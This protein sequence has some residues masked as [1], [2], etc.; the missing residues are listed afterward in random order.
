MVEVRVLKSAEIG[1][2]LEDIAALRSTVFR[3]WP[4][5]YDGS[6]DYE[7][8]YIAGYRDHPGALIV[9]ALDGNRLVGV[10][11]STPMEDLGADFAEPFP[12]AGPSRDCILWGPESVLQPTFRDQ[13]IG[14][15]FYA[16]R[17]AHARALGRTH[18][19]FA[20]VLRPD[21]HPARPV[22]ARTTDAFWRRLGYAPS[23]GFVAEFGWRDIG[24]EVETTKPLQ[25]WI[26][27]L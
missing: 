24:S 15:Q 10:S 7:R 18:V 17:E 9:G 11:T 3:D 1:T 4:Y 5:L 14:R 12:A 21:D 16:L 13:G 26:K 23:P 27:A 2:W 19:A 22:A 8:Q 6:L 20:Q 25:V